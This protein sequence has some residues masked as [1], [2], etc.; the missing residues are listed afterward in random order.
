MILN[1][2]SY[3]PGS[4]VIGE[5]FL[6]GGVGIRGLAIS[7]NQKYAYLADHTNGLRILDISDLKNPLMQ[8]T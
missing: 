6:G 2:L 3:L 1:L 4:G 5:R 8:I 7:P